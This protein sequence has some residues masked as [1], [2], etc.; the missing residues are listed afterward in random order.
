MPK[1]QRTRGLSSSNFLRPYHKYKHKSWSNF[2][3]WISSKRQLKNLNQTSRQNLN[4]N[5]APESRP[6]FS[7][8]TSSKHQWQNT[9]QTPAS[10]YCRNV[11]FKIL[12]KPCALSVNKILTLWPNLEAS[13]PKSATNCCQQ[14]PRHNICPKF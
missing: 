4:F 6:R 1:A 9:N 7:L 12:N 2:I 8:I 11:N 13:A 3:F 10:K 5:L 14:D